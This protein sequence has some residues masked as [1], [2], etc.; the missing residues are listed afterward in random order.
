MHSVF[1][2]SGKKSLY[3]TLKCD[4]IVG[5]AYS[6]SKPSQLCHVSL[7]T[8]K[9]CDLNGITEFSGL[10]NWFCSSEGYPAIWSHLKVKYGL[11]SFFWKHV[12]WPKRH[13]SS[14]EPVR[15]SKKKPTAHDNSPLA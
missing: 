10:N 4:P 12:V 9:G 11:L 5:F 7:K 13:E 8:A 3:F 14:P 2:S 1:I 6:A 15:Q